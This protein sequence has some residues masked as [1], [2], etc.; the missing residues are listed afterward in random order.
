MNPNADT[1]KFEEKRRKFIVWCRGLK[2]IGK[3]GFR[4]ENAEGREKLLAGEAELT[5]E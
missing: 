4:Q 2:A 5:G 1:L 3:W